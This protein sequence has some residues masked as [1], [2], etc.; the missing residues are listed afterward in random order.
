[1]Y[2]VVFLEKLKTNVILP[3]SWIK[4]IEDHF[5]KFMNRSI[6]RSQALLCYYTTNLE[7]F[8]ANK[9]PRKDWPASFGNMVD[10]PIDDHPFDGCFLG[11]LQ[12]FKGKSLTFISLIRI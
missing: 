2:F 5:E 9:C 1:M 4:D 10:D 11:F 8:E 12:Q 7:A 6:N 3:A